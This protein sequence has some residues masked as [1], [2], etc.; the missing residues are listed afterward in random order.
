MSFGLVDEKIAKE[1]ATDDETKA[2]AVRQARSDADALHQRIEHLGTDEL[3]LLFRQARS[4]NGWLD[5]T[6]SDQQLHELYDLLKM[7]PTSMNC[8]PARFVFIRSAE[9]KERL[10]PALSPG[11][12]EKTMAAPVIVVIGYDLAFTEFL[13]QLFPHTDGRRFFVDKPEHTAT[14]AFRNGTLQGAYLMLAARSLGLDCGPMS[15]FD[16]QKVD[17]EFF[18]GSSI[19][20]NF[21]C[22]LGRGD[23][24]KLFQRHPR[25]G[26]QQAC[27]LV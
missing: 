2:L 14:T 10:R 22:G 26:F 4:H 7:G 18:P 5:E 1:A 17:A 12:I 9:G 15:G 23:S 6:V 27:E 3:D 21:L 24:R 19:K 20:S 16:H 25:L 13:P 11:N 8:S